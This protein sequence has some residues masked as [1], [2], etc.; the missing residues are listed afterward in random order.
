MDHTVFLEAGPV[1]D[2]A[3]R[4]DGEWRVFPYPE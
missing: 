1:K 4:R 2:R 3:Q